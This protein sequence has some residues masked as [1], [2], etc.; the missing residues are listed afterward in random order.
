MPPRR[1]GEAPPLSSRSRSRRR[2]RRRRSPGP[3]AGGAPSS[4]YRCFQKQ[5]CD[6]IGRRLTALGD[7]W[8]QGKLS[9]PV[10][11]RMALLVRGE[12]G[13][14]RSAVA[15]SGRGTP[16]VSS[17][18]QNWSGAAGTRPTRSTAR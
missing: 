9:A 12:G 10:R 2:P 4:G 18:R 14:A 16:T 11:R 17:S 8:A 15:R 13:G 3:S 1:E 7:A 5:V 6:D